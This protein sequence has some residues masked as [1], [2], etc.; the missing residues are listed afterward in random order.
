MQDHN[1]KQKLGIS[2]QFSLQLLAIHLSQGSGGAPES[3]PKVASMRSMRQ[4]QKAQAQPL[5]YLKKSRPFQ[6]KTPFHN[7]CLRLLS[8][9]RL[10]V[11]LAL[12][13]LKA[14]MRLLH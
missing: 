11:F 6:K 5:A 14:R 12:S 4:N 3:G 1:W 2:H 10:M 7:K 13:S 8:R 9:R